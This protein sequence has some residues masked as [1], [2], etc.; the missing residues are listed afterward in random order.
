MISFLHTSWLVSTSS[1]LSDILRKGIHI[2]ILDS[3]IDYLHPALGGGFD[4]GFK[5]IKGYDFAGNAYTGENVPV[6]SGL[7]PYTNRSIH[8][9]QAAGIIGASQ[10]EYNFIDVVPIATLSMHKVFGCDGPTQD[11]ILIKATLATP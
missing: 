10:N 3:G 6:D 8:G 9:T 1:T 4:P 2:A 5:V 11:D 7:D